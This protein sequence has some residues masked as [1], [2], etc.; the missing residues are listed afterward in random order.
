MLTVRTVLLRHHNAQGSHF[1]WLM[2]DPAWAGPM[3][4]DQR[5]LWASRVELDTGD[6]QPAGRWLVHRLPPH[7]RLYLHH[8][9]P[10]GGGRGTVTRVDE[11]ESAIETWSASR[12]VVHVL[13]GRFCG[14]VQLERVDGA[15]WEAKAVGG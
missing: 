10:I 11:G 4:D 13:M 1:D 6:W 12:C 8:E 15:L 2:E 7:R 3:D 9:G 14:R 5:G